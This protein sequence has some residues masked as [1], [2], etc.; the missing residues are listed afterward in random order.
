MKPGVAD[1]AEA[2]H[3]GKGVVIPLTHEVLVELRHRPAHIPK[4]NV[5]NAVDG[6]ERVD[7]LQDR[8][9]AT[10]L[11][12]DRAL[13]QQDTP[14][15]AVRHRHRLTVGVRAPEDATNTAQ[16]RNRRVGRMD[17]KQDPCVLCDRKHRTKEI[18]VVGP[19]VVV[20]DDAVVG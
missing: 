7:H 9:L 16:H 5:P 6:A 4:V 13:A 11:L 3:H 8:R 15:L 20:G 14:G 18:V 2:L 1:L 10:R 17:R 19:H 12:R